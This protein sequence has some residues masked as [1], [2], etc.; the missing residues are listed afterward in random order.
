M[1]IYFAGNPGGNAA[2]RERHESIVVVSFVFF[3]FN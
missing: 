2:E 3:F 1:K